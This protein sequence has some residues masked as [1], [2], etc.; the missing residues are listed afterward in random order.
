MTVFLVG[1]GS[2]TGATESV[3]HRAHVLVKLS[4]K[5]WKPSGMRRTPTCPFE[6]P[7]IVIVSLIIWLL[8]HSAGRL[9]CIIS[10]S[11]TIPALLALTVTRHPR[12][13]TTHPG[14][15]FNISTHILRSSLRIFHSHPRRT[16]PI[17]SQPALPFI[18]YIACLSS[19]LAHH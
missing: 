1:H 5:S 3:Y 4:R 2:R 12:K 10:Q 13:L 7:S 14:P 17:C 9:C 16:H 15:R 18:G 11:Y 19:S 6:L 8:S